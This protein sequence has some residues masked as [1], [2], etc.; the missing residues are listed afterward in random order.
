[1]SILSDLFSGGIKDVIASVGSVIDDVVTSDEERLTLKN[2][3]SVIQNKADERKMEFEEN[4]EK[5]RTARHASDMKSDSWLSKNIRPMSLIFLLGFVSILS[6]TDGNLQWAYGPEA[7][8]KLWEFDIRAEYITLYQSLLLMAFGFYF[9]SRGLE[10]L[11]T[12]F[13]GGKS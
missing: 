6:L 2:A 4:E 12:I 11:M 3:L 8:I 9:S 1:M 5:E 13:K 10:K 7:D